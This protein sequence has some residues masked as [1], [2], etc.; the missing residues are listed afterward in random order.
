MP[1]SGIFLEYLLIDRSIKTNKRHNQLI[2]LSAQAPVSTTK[3][4]YAGDRAGLI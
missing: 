3:G 1:V 4:E 2:D